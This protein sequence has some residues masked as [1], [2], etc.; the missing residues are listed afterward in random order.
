MVTGSPPKKHAKLKKQKL[1]ENKIS[2][3]A[4]NRPEQVDQ[5]NPPKVRQADKRT[6]SPGSPRRVKSKSLEGRDKDQAKRMDL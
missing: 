5:P 4:N 2:T 1:T 3:F 6:K